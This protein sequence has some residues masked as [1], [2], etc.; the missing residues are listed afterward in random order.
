MIIDFVVN[1]HLQGFDGFGQ[2]EGYMATEFWKS[3]G[4]FEFQLLIFDIK[5][6]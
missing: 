2:I 4:L 5:L 3:F 6:G 1:N